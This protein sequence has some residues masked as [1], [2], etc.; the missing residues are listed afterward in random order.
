MCHFL[1]AL[2]AVPSLVSTVLLTVDMHAD[3]EWWVY[4]LQHHNGASII[5]INVTLA[6]PTLFACD[7][8]VTGCG[9]VCFGENFWSRSQPHIL[10]LP[11][12]HI[13]E[14]VLLWWLLSF[15]LRGFK[16]WSLSFTLI[17]PFTLLWSIT[18]LPSMSACNVVYANSDSTFQ[19][20]IFPWSS[21]LYQANKTT[22]LIPSA[23]IM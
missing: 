4:F 23:T 6:N 21:N 3:I 20:T 19:I 13:N 1:N 16:D 12:L 14:L 22:L 10:T 2:H 5:P 11:G 9:A 15:G 18:S 17:I 7:A 8:C